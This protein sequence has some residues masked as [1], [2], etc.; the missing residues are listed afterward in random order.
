MILLDHVIQVLALPQF[1]LGCQG[2]VC[3][4]RFNRHRIGSI[5]IDA[6]DS[7]RLGMSRLQH[8]TEKPG[9]GFAISRWA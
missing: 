6:N 2:F 7:R 4:Q 9:G 3:F 5:F 8:F 1:G